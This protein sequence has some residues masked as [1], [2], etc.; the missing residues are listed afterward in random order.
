M[1]I[2]LIYLLYTMFLE[3]IKI[4]TYSANFALACS[5]S[6]AD[7]FSFFFNNKIY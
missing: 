2:K 7:L 3:V 6:L 4:N 5:S 1:N